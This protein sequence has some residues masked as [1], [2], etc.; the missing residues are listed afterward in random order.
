MELCFHRSV[1]YRIHPDSLVS[2]LGVATIASNAE[3]SN[4]LLANTGM[5][6]RFNKFSVVHDN[7][8]AQSVIALYSS[9][10]ALYVFFY[11]IYYYEKLAL[12]LF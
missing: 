7:R 1:A 10:V 11:N 5:L 9:L 6:R 3:A 8:N 4:Q 2:A 12:V